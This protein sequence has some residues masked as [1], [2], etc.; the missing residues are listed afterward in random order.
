MFEVDFKILNQKATPAIYAD[1]LALRPA[2]G[3]AGRLFV[4]TDSPYGVYRDTGTTWV[5]VASNGTG[6]PGSTGVNGLNGTTNIGLGGTLIQNTLITGLF[7]LT[8]AAVKQISLSSTSVL[9]D[10]GINT[11]GNQYYSF[12]ND[13]SS[14]YQTYFYQ[15]SRRFYTTFGNAEFGL[16]LDESTGKFVIGDYANGRKYNSFVVNDD[17]NTF[18][19]TTSYNQNNTN[20]DLF[21]AKNATDRFVKI[22]DF[23]NYNNGFSLIIDDENSFIKTQNLNGDNGITI[24]N[25]F[26]LVGQNNSVKQIFFYVDYGLN[27]IATYSSATTINGLSLDYDNKIYKFGGFGGN[28]NL[29]EI[30]DN[31]EKIT[32]QTAE[33]FFTGA[34]LQSNTSSGNSGEHLVITLNG[35]QY[36]I[37]L[38]NP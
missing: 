33:I 16:N 1:T 23:N 37:A 7:D 8:I 11:N 25:N 2:A 22:G 18:Y 20:Q 27:I 35:T 29:I 28:N 10:S 31:V 17:N 14:T 38:Q 32:F 5:Q 30:D 36:K 34:A 6:G 24:T 21:Y 26:T 15:Q 4:A 3:F 19:L 12:A 13:G 9:G